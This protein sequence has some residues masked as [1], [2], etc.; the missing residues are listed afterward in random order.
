MWRGRLVY[1]FSFANMEICQTHSLWGGSAAGSHSWVRK[2]PDGNN[3]SHKNGILISFQRKKRQARPSSGPKTNS[4]A[5]VSSSETQG[6]GHWEPES[7]ARWDTAAE[8]EGVLQQLCFF[9][10]PKLLLSWPKIN[11]LSFSDWSARVACTMSHWAFFG[12]K[13]GFDGLKLY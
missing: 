7:E 9:F 6:W 12:S 11:L 4:P 5:V 10:V 13:L 2:L 1:G 3:E 8:W